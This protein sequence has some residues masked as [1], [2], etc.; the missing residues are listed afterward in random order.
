MMDICFVLLGR[1]PSWWVLERPNRFSGLPNLG[2][3]LSM[4]ATTV[5]S[6]IGS[7]QVVL[8]PHDHISNVIRR[9]G[10]PYEP[11]LVSIVRELTKPGRVI[12][13]VGANLGN[14]TIYWAKAGRR[15]IAFE[16]NLLTRSALLESVRLNN[17]HDR[18]DVRS[19]ALGARTGTGT[20]HSLLAGNQGAV[21]VEPT[22]DGEI[23]VVRLD[24]L[25]LPHFSV[26]KIDVEGSEE[27]VILGARETI[28]RVRPIIVAEALQDDGGV[29]SLLR[30]LGYYRLP[31]SLAGTPTYLYV[32]VAKSVSVLLRS[33]TL[34]RRLARGAAR[35]LR[36]AAGSVF[37][38]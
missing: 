38:S 31:T 13:D 6:D 14:H 28:R 4:S 11:T 35:R 17:L 3:V 27:S 10:A 8:L 23:P 32:P 18:V 24:D 1:A 26:I 16:P 25:A 5:N 12:V 33:P 2:S 9:S 22:V 19:V 15:V 37:R 36:R 21:A 29:A 30:D 7:Y 20:L 34:A